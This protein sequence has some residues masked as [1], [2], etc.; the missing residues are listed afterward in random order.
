MI[1]TLSEISKIINS[2]FIGSN[3]YDIEYILIDS[4]TIV[5][6]QQTLFF[7]INGE[8]HDA[9]KFINE[10]Y[11]KGIRSFVV[12]KLPENYIDLKDASFLVVK[13]AILA[14]QK[15]AAYH[16]KRF[17]Y[18]VIGIT[19]SNGKTI[20]KEWLYYILQI[21]KC[22]VRSPKSFN[23][24]IGVP[25]SVW[26]MDNLFD[27]A[28][29][30]AGI[31]LPNEMERL[32][33]IL[34]P[35]IGLITNISEP[36]QE[37]FNDLE[38]KAIEKLK[39]F[40]GSK[41]L[42]YCKDHKLIHDLISKDK[43]LSKKQLFIWSEAEESD[44]RIISTDKSENKTIIHYKYKNSNYNITIPFT[45]KAFIEDA[46]HVLALVLALGLK[47]NDY[48]SRFEYLPSVAMRMELKSGVNNCTIINDS[49]NS[50]LNS[51]SI[52]LNYLNQQNQHKRKTVILSDILQSGKSNNN[53]YKEIAELISKFKIDKLIGIGKSIS[54]QS[55]KFDVQCEF[56]KSTQEFLSILTDNYFSDE[57]ILLKGSRQFYFE[58]ISAAIEEK[59]N[60][61]V[62]EIN[63][64][65]LVHNLNHFKSKLLP[66][67]KIMV[68]VKALAYGSGTYE[69]ANVLQYQG[70]DFLGVA[71]AD[72][73]VA[74]RQA[75]I[76]TRIIV[77]N[78]ENNS[79]DLMLE[80]NLEPEIYNFKVL[81]QFQTIV[82]K[83]GLKNYPI[84]IK[85]DSGMHR[86][87][88]V[89]SEL[90][91]LI[92]EIKQSDCFKVS[93]VFSHLAASDEPE[94][95][96]FTLE[97]IDAFESMSESIMD[98]FSYLIDRHILNSAGIERFSDAQFEIVRLGIGLYGISST[99][100]EQLEVVSTLKSNVLQ[101]KQVAKND[102]VGYSRKAKAVEDI[103]IAVIPIGYADGL[104]RRMGNGIGTFFING[105]Y[106]P[107]IGNVCMDMCM[108][109]ITGC[110]I[111][112]GDEAILFGKERSVLEIARL[113]NT[114]PY[115]IF[116]GISTRVKR[117]YF[118]E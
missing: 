20:V 4:R 26:L 50:D 64:N 118:Q 58:K 95:D 99:E 70:V 3:D 73:G 78:P 44:L 97:Q 49:Y 85:L 47:S 29:F 36:H 5:T 25:L 52:A 83:K 67:T 62:L 42:V 56:Y 86:L 55:E 43:E 6:T 11:Q 96:S 57:A 51:L 23:S 1:Y 87:G 116:T 7:A 35:D 28:I 10:L 14:L 111:H 30:E 37:N 15:L 93:S 108:V 22:V 45:H 33:N 63:L 61:T 76:K 54:E 39:L 106:V 101:I 115:E 60:R 19:G 94:H 69:I 117:V 32:Q 109:D 13:N 12:E 75:G 105:C 102:T 46:I 72:E 89:A 40:T 68:M 41:V 74:L 114:I 8:R 16:R 59:V 104:D 103:T 77:M 9:H 92:A 34:N 110:N 88:F 81:R 17:D 38:Q 53:L 48:A 84:H 71:M 112:E 90:H 91:Q 113:L 79:F 107:I 31:S 2:E 18:P 98:E 24:Q 82:S 66:K 27:L 100:Q 80:Y 21:E 65:A